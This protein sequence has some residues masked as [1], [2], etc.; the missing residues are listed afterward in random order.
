MLGRKLR[1][2]IPDRMHG[3]YYISILYNDPRSK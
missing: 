1:R 3:I 2:G